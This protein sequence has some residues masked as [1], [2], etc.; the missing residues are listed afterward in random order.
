M[1]FML[2]GYYYDEIFELDLT[3]TLVPD[4]E[5]KTI[6]SVTEALLNKVKEELLSFKVERYK[7]QPYFL[8]SFSLIKEDAK[9]LVKV[10]IDND[11]KESF[12][13]ASA[14]GFRRLQ[15]VSISNDDVLVKAMLIL[16]RSR[17]IVNNDKSFFALFDLRIV[18]QD[19]LLIKLVPMVE[20]IGEDDENNDVDDDNP[21]L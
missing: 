8:Y 16:D 3:G 6:S 5:S 21:Y 14:M 19:I 2:D 9:I 20:N 7:R 12:T 10:E 15:E 1:P 11:F 13:S 18:C 17:T 4:K